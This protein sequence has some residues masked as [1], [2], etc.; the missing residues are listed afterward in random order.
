MMKPPDDI[1]KILRD[2]KKYDRM[3]AIGSLI[4]LIIIVLIGFLGSPV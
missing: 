3:I 1:E 4:V 2:R